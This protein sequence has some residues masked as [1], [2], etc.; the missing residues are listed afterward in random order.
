MLAQKALDT[1][2][3]CLPPAWLWS[4]TML[5]GTPAVWGV[6]SSPALPGHHLSDMLDPHPHLMRPVLTALHG[7]REA[8][9]TFFLDPSTDP[10]VIQLVQ[11]HG[12]EQVIP[13]PI[14]GCPCIGKV[15]PQN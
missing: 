5:C 10:S 11:L 8:V 15:C 6:P 4:G 12:Q 3:W 14:P 9:T 1:G 13:P 2:V 7:D